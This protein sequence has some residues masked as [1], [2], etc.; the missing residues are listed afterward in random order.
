LRRK[1]LGSLPKDR[2]Q[3]LEYSL[4]CPEMMICGEEVRFDSKRLRLRPEVSLTFLEVMIQELW[5]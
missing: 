5:R 3:R 4:T 1:L 2:G